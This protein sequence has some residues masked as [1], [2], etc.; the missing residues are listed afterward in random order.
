MT[1][2]NKQ[3]GYVLNVMSVDRP[4]IVAGV[5]AAICRLQGNIESC[6][7]TVLN[8]YF[9][10]IMTFTLPKE[11][12]IEELEATILEEKGH[13]LRGKGGLSDCQAMIRPMSILPKT[14]ENPAKPNLFVITAFGGDCKGIVASFSEYLAGKE[15]NIID[16]YGNLT[17]DGSFVLI[18]QVEVS[19]THDVRNIQLDLEELGRELG[20]TV[21]LQHDN[22]FVA[23]NRIRI[24]NADFDRN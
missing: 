19:P 23:T 24:D 6:S 20:F 14:E 15:I 1:E 13:S 11:W 22:I 18:G 7:Q 5:S 8:G 17:P 4:G 16:L 9:T 3:Y 12:K 21:K 10:L 2:S